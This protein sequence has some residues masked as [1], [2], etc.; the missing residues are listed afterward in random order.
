MPAASVEGGHKDEEDA[1]EGQPGED[2]QPV[3][4]RLGLLV[5]A[6][7][8]GVV[9]GGEATVARRRCTSL[10]NVAQG[11]VLGDVRAHVDASRAV[12]SQD[13][14]RCRDDRDVGELADRDL[15]PSEASMSSSRTLSGLYRTLGGLQTW[16]S[17]FLPFRQMSP[18]SSLEMNAAAVLRTSPGLMPY[19][20]AL[21]R[22]T[23]MWTCG[24]RVCRVTCSST[25]PS[26]PPR[27][28]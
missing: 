24:T 5:L 16:T 18:A 11:R 27:V 23:S 21:T 9:P 3:L 7:Q 14:V 6:E 4:C 12:L 15:Q 26:T 8:L 1:E 22:S 13:L 17:V 20:E 28:P 25:M 19:S 2:E 10:G